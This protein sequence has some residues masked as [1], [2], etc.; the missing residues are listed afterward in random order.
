MRP[1]LRAL[2]GIRPGATYPMRDRVTLGR[3]AVADVQLIDEAVS[4]FHALI[5]QQPDGRHVIADLA[6]KAGTRVDGQPVGRTVLEVGSV[7]EICGFRLR[8]ELVDG[9]APPA[10]VEK[11][12][13]YVAV[14]QT[15]SDLVAMEARVG[16]S[17]SSSTADVPDVRVEEPTRPEPAAVALPPEW[18]VLLRE[19][20]E[21]RALVDRGDGASPR[22]FALADRFLAS[23]RSS[24]SR[25][26]RRSRRFPCATPVLLGLRR[27]ADVVTSVA[28]MLDASAD[29]VRL[30]TDEALPVGLVCWLLVATGDGERA[31]IAFSARV[32]WTHTAAREAGFTFIGRPVAGP[33]VLPPMRPA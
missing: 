6:S 15:R 18:L 13:G 11:V 22:A 4:R 29:G 5:E 2:S 28:H 17:A 21:Y 1:V 19:L 26:R 12:H 14:R 16:A 9:D 25:G 30:R 7:V 20:V 33:D 8:Y 27:G 24:G 32:A 23:D 10:L 3:A 31:G